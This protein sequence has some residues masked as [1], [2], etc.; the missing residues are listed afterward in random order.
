MIMIRWLRTVIIRR[1]LAIAEQRGPDFVIGRRSAPYVLRWWVIPRNRWFNIYL[2]HFLSS[3]DDRALHDHP[4]WNVSFVL[5]GSYTEI[6][7]R[8]DRQEG[9]FYEHH[10]Y[11]RA[12][13]I[14]F[15]SARAAHRIRLDAG[16]CWTLF[17]TG[18]VLREWGFL[19]PQGWR[20][21]QEFA[22][23]GD[24]GEIGRGCD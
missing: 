3:D 15:R 10:R 19:C 7:R 14:H 13:N 4:W 12:G 5:L 21:W 2:H 24:K 1:C 16:D 6:T 18:P 23:P 17:I 9:Y 8:R 11:A 20:P 22:A